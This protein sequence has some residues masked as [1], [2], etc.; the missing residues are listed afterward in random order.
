[1][2]H[3]INRIFKS[4]LL[5]YIA[6]A[7]LL[8]YSTGCSAE[9]RERQRTNREQK[10]A[11]RNKLI[12]ANYEVELLLDNMWLAIFTVKDE[13]SAGGYKLLEKTIRTNRR[14][15]PAE[16]KHL[17]EKEQQIITSISRNLTRNGKPLSLTKKE[18]AV[19]RNIISQHGGL[20]AIGAKIDVSIEER[21]NSAEMNFSAPP[22]EA[23]R[24]KVLITTN[25][26]RALTPS[27]ALNTPPVDSA[28]KADEKMRLVELQDGGQFQVPSE[29]SVDSSD[30]D[31]I[32]VCD[33][34]GMPIIFISSFPASSIFFQWPHKQN[35]ASKLEAFRNEQY[36]L[37]ESKTGELRKVG[38]QSEVVQWF[39]P[40]PL[41][42][43]NIPACGIDFVRKDITHVMGKESEVN[44]Y[45]VNIQILSKSKIHIITL[46]HPS[47]P[48]G[49]DQNVGLP[50]IFTDIF[51]SIRFK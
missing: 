18:K 9:F 11:E 16:L 32:K 45:C 46:R 50:K 10:L 34:K 33:E 48:L 12:L 40:Y 15:E 24:S 7:I 23:D 21:E 44:T 14:L 4:H 37:E 47:N 6:F 27:T 3:A 17:C 39:S 51:Q 5:T 26:S 41:I 49:T 13:M 1:M 42:H 2:A 31:L 35:I 19:W 8:S 25:N 28:V 30:T 20:K 43:L 38:L 22:I 29:F 36:L